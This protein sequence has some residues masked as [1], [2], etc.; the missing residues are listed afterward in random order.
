MDRVGLSIIL[1]RA[2]PFL[3][4]LIYRINRSW[5]TTASPVVATTLATVHIFQ[6]FSADRRESAGFPVR[7]TPTEY[8]ELH[9]ERPYL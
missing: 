6:F 9:G 5:K 7:K 1:I 2:I 3:I 8:A 4:I